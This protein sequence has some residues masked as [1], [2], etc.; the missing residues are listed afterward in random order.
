MKIRNGFVSNSSSSSFI[1]INSKFIKIPSRYKGNPIIIGESGETEFGWQ[2]EKYFDFE[3]KLNFCYIQAMYAY[4]DGNKCY[5]DM[6]DRILKD[7]LKCTHTIS[8]ITLKYNLVDPG[9]KWGCI[10]HES[11]YPKNIEMFDSFKRL[12]D[13][14]FSTKSYIQNGNDNE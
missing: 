1:V 6:L 5:L 14:L 7:N 11:S 13:F 12:Y 3:S 4:E 2:T 8:I 10:D 9:M